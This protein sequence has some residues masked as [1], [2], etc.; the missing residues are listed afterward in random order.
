[1]LAVRDSTPAA[2][3]G[4]GREG[5]PSTAAAEWEQLKP[6]QKYFPNK[7]LEDYVL[8][9]TNLLGAFGALQGGSAGALQRIL[10]FYTGEIKIGKLA[11]KEY[12][13]HEH[14]ATAL[15]AADTLFKA[16]SKGTKSEGFKLTHFGGLVIRPNANNPAVLSEHS[17]GAA[18]DLDAE[19]NPNERGFP[20]ELIEDVTGDDLRAGASGTGVDLYNVTASGSCPE[21][22]RRLRRGVP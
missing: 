16:K 11:E 3:G 20:F 22:V 12:P 15:A 14:M 2:E 19:L 17:L 5:A 4:G 18:I 7:K 10:A 9:R 8:V 1:M 13:V 21:R 6:V